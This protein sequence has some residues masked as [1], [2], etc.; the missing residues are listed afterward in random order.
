MPKQSVNVVIVLGRF[1]LPRHVA[2]HLKA[3][4]RDFSEIGP[5]CCRF[6]AEVMKQEHLRV[7]NMNVS[8]S[9]LGI[10][11]V[12]QKSLVWLEQHLG[13]VESNPVVLTNVQR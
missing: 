1:W 3:V 4:H 11:D 6:S 9:A 7:R 13:G 10:M 8:R 5:E 12:A 2:I